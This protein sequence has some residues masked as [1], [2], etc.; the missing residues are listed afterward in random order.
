MDY[1]LYGDTDKESVE[2]EYEIH[3][4]ASYEYEPQDIIDNL[5]FC[6][7]HLYKHYRINIKDLVKKAYHFGLD[8]SKTE[9]EDNDCRRKAAER[10]IL[11][12]PH[13][14]INLKHYK[15]QND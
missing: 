13:K 14:W 4:V 9:G 6:E 8:F 10:I 3:K 1:T 5:H 15:R 11:E 2:T 7:Y 12:T